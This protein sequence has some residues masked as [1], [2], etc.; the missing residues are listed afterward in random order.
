MLFHVH[1]VVDVF[2]ILLTAGFIVWQ[3][4]WGYRILKVTLTFTIRGIYNV[5]Q[6]IKVHVSKQFLM[7]ILMGFGAIASV[8]ILLYC[9][10][11]TSKTQQETRTCIRHV[12]FETPNVGYNIRELFCQ[13][14]QNREQV[15]AKYRKA[16]AENEREDFAKIKK[17]LRQ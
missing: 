16:K 4:Y 2:L 1:P 12:Q 13:N 8:S 3:M 14:S 6:K 5:T 9:V 15:L 10:I 17:A 11:S 7:L